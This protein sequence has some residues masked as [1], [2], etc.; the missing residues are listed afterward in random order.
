[1]SDN[2]LRSLKPRKRRRVRPAERAC[3]LF[4]RSAACVYAPWGCRVWLCMSNVWLLYLFQV[5]WLVYGRVERHSQMLSV[6]SFCSAGSSR[7]DGDGVN[8]SWLI[9]EVTRLQ[10]LQFSAE[11]HV[12]F[13][14]YDQC[15][16]ANNALHLQAVMRTFRSLL[17]YSFY[18]Q[19][20]LLILRHINSELAVI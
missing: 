5:S 8:V 13:G 4:R 9:V 1:M 19:S 6:V 18:K 3:N 12:K 2:G 7:A 16:N 15:I 14:I 20:Q 11:K 17:K 10:K